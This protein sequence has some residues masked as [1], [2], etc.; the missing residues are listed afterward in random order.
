VRFVGINTR[1]LR[2]ANA[3]AFENEYKITYPSL[4]DPA[5]K[6]VLKFPKGTVNP[7]DIP[8]TVIIDRDGKIAVRILHAVGE[9]ELSSAV[10]SVAAE[11]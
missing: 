6:L 9:D 7:Q 8:S 3:K 11:K 10:R 1:D 2:V 4:F 5:G